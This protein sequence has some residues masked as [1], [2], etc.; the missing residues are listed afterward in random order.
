[1]T[2][3]AHVRLRSLEAGMAWTWSQTSPLMLVMPIFSR[4]GKL[5]ISMP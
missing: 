4:I 2:E 5:V 3:M 1:M